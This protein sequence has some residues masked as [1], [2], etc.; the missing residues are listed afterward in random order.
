MPMIEAMNNIWKNIS[1]KNIYSFINHDIAIR[2]DNESSERSEV[3]VKL[4]TTFLKGYSE[5]I[6]IYL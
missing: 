4:A 6:L 1:H 2:I 5:S 3:K